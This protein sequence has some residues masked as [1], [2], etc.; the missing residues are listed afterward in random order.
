MRVIGL[1]GGIA[2]GK[3]T[4]GALLRA[5]GAPV[6]DADALARAAVEPGTPALPEIARTFGAEVL[7][8]DGALDRKALAAR[9]FADPE[10]R[11]R[12]EA[13]THPA[14]RRAM[15]EATDR[16][17]AQGHPLAFYDT[18]LLYE[19]GL[20]ALLD[21]VVVVWAPRDVQ[22]ER[23]I[24]RDGLDAAE[25]DAR[26]AAQ[27]PVDEKAARAD[28]VI[29]NAGAPEALAGKADRLLADLRAGRGRRLPN[30]PPVRY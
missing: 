8:E 26:L 5:R 28:F 10:A 7:R 18:P 22:R 6:V 2:T 12:L 3:S 4:F 20:E 14:V 19:V 11:R 21:A 1:T 16:L 30:A 25:V 17:A 9:V 29:D 23:L 27:L 15:R 24:R 13:I